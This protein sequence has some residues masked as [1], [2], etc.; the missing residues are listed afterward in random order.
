[1]IIIHECEELKKMESDRNEKL[2]DFQ[3]ALARLVKDPLSESLTGLD[4]LV[5]EAP[6]SKASA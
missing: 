5:A 4:S 1:M 2:N 3:K 6:D